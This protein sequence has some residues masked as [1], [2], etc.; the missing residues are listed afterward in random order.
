MPFLSKE[1]ICDK[2]H[3]IQEK[4]QHDITG[5]HCEADSEKHFLRRLSNISAGPCSQFLFLLTA[6][7]RFIMTSRHA[8]FIS[9]PTNIV[10]FGYLRWGTQM[11]QGLILNEVWKW[12]PHVEL[13]RKCVEH[14]LLP[15][16]AQRGITTCKHC[17]PKVEEGVQSLHLLR[18]TIGKQFAVTGCGRCA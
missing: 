16:W 7:S 15:M 5:V 2:V 17:R 8:D 9:S 6:L 13:C 14:L 4:A 11:A 10:P 18:E 1:G 12:P 3:G